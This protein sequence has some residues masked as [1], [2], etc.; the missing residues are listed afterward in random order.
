MV[1]WLVDW[2]VGWLIGWLVG[3]LLN[4]PVDRFFTLHF[5]GD[6]SPPHPKEIIQKQN[7]TTKCGCGWKSLSCMWI[8][9]KRIR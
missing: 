3:W 2:L 8:R 7:I 4:Q 5:R 1:G 9:W 6:K